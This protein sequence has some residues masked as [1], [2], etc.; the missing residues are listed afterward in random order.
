MQLVKGETNNK[1]AYMY[2]S[3]IYTVIVS[4]SSQNTYRD[5]CQELGLVVSHRPHHQKQV[6]PKGHTGKRGGQM[7][8]WTRL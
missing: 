2:N 7:E 3:L 4:D 1:K 5:E 8:K 6:L